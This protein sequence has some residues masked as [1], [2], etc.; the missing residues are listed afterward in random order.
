MSIPTALKTLLKLR[1]PNPL[2][3]PGLE[4]L[5]PI[6]LTTLKEASAHKAENGWLAVA[7][8]TFL[9][10]NSPSVV[11][12]L[13]R[14]A[15][16][17]MDCNGTAG[18]GSPT[19]VSLPSTEPFPLKER[20]RRAAQMR[21]AGLKS[22]VFVGV[23]KVINSLAALTESLEDDVKAAL[24][25]I[26]H[27]TLLNESLGMEKVA[28]RGHKLFE[29]IYHPHTL[30]L[31]AKL[32]KYH[33]DFPGH[34]ITYEYGSLLSDPVGWSSR[35]EAVINRALTSAVGV[36]CLRASG[37]VGPQLT[38]HVYGLLKARDFGEELS[39]G[40][41]WLASADGATWVLGVV[42][43]LVD[44]L[45]VPDTLEQNGASQRSE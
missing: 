10:A 33:P 25:T 5:A 17:K 27:R 36:A 40:D 23:P 16:H 32:G 13:Y 35:A 22:V 1:G 37:G 29:S 30:K 41:Q 19:S 31:L 8:A 4:K 18:S 39:E 7:T 9:A 3:N 20:T 44:S 26:P 45:H 15:S 38:S 14:F 24:T 6:F 43:R 12:D 34:I 42:D 28:A 11:G 21:E 2:P